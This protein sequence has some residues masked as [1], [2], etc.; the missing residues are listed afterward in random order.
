MIVYGDLLFIE[1]LIIGCALLYITGELFNKKFYGVQSKLRLMA[2]GAFCGVFSMTV[3]LPVRMPVTVILE[4]FF[5][6]A[7]CWV[8]FGRERL[9]HKAVAFILVT[10]FMGGITMGLLFVTKNPGIYTASG[11]YT[12]DMK[13]GLL[14]IFMSV[15]VFTAK[16]IIKTVSARKFF[17][18]HVLAVRISIGE[19]VFETKGFFDSG[20][21]LTE[22]L[23]GKPVAVAQKS[24]WQ[25]LEESGALAPERM[26]VV[27]YEA[28]GERGLMASVRA[29]FIEVNGMPIKGVVIAKGSEELNLDG[30]AAEGCELLLSRDMSGREI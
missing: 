18:E 1:N 13:A 10:Y 6:F 23:S 25:R 2:G 29:D 4:I 28:I 5:A 11:I 3:F 24:L 15:G 7:V 22:P 21:Q 12:G 8:V 30:K 9:I 20:N 27:P 14:A 17:T 19:S 16:Q 26:G